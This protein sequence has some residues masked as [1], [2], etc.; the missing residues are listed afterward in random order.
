M[1]DADYFRCSSDHI[2]L[3][4]RLTPKSSRDAIGSIVQTDN[5]YALQAFVRA[6]P[7]DGAANAAL[8]ALIAK[9]LRISKSSI[10]L[11]SGQKSRVKVLAI[12]GDFESLK[13]TM[14][15]HKNVGDYPSYPCTTT[16]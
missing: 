8:V 13:R 11:R 14:T 10:E 6:L 3:R 7:K 5:H 1:A 9:W 16:T 12:T 4:V 2:E 15:E